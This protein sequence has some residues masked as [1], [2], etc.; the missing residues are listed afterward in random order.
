M[1]G[2]EVAESVRG[3]VSLYVREE[4]LIEEKTPV[5]FFFFY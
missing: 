1:K 4:K 3:I 5:K 2:L